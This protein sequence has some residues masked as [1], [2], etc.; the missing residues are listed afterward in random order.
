MTVDA[1]GEIEPDDI[2]AQV[3]KVDQLRNN[4]HGHSVF[5]VRLGRDVHFQVTIDTQNGGVQEIKSMTNILAEASRAN[6][7]TNTPETVQGWFDRATA[8]LKRL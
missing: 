6:R 5:Q 2:E 8:W 4:V 1:R 3:F 7:T